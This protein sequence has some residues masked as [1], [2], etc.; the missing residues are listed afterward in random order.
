MKKA[1]FLQNVEVI[2]QRAR[3]IFINVDNHAAEL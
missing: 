2:Y 1:F 3:D